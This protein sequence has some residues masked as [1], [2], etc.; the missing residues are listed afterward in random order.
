MPT[1]TPELA[2]LDYTPSLD[3]LA[4]PL[5]DYFPSSLPVPPLSS[6]TVSL[7]SLTNTPATSLLQSPS[8]PAAAAAPPS[9]DGASL[10]AG[11]KLPQPKP[12]PK[13]GRR[14]AG[15]SLCRTTDGRVTKRSAA[16]AS[17][18]ATPYLPADD[19]AD[20]EVIDRRHRNNLAAKR[21]RQKKIDRI[22]ELEEEVSEVKQERDDLK[23]RLARQ[24]AEVAALREMLKMKNG[25]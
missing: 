19:D 17:S 20:P 9:P 14:P 25:S 16:A 13:P 6:G 18:A 24:E 11:L 7:S 23:I 2:D 5:F 1:F 22:Q 8:P 15:A 3:T 12:A 4:A 21:Y 10:V